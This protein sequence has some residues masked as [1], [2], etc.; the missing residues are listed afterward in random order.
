MNPAVVPA[1]TCIR[2]QAAY[3]VNFAVSGCRQCM[4]TAPSNLRVTYAPEARK[5]WR[6]DGRDHNAPGI[7]RYADM[8]PLPRD[9]AVSLGEG[10]TPLVATPRI[11]TRLGL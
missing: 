10:G 7:W 6:L 2:C 11:A 3:P 1:L 9:A 5:R 8:L 4:G